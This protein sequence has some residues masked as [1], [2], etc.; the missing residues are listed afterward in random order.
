M[1]GAQ[2][3]CSPCWSDSCPRSG[4][5]AAPTSRSVR[6]ARAFALRSSRHL[7][8]TQAVQLDHTLYA[9]ADV[10]LATYQE[11]ADVT[12]AFHE[13]PYR[14]VD[15]FSAGMENPDDLFVS[16][17]E[18][19]GV[20]D[21]TVEGRIANPER[22]SRITDPQFRI[23]SEPRIARTPDRGLRPGSGLSTA[24]LPSFCRQRVFHRFEFLALQ[25]LVE[26]RQIDAENR[27]ELT[28]LFIQTIRQ[29]LEYRVR[30]IR[31]LVITGF[32]DALQCGQLVVQPDGIVERI[33]AAAISILVD[34]A[35]DRRQLRDGAA[36]PLP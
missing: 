27:V 33:L 20:V 12:L 36:P 21:V 2:T 30:L 14:P 15:L 8:G 1:T 7:P 34:L 25:Q 28:E 26:C 6:I 17:E 18:P 11:I 3:A 10:V 5:T 16:L 23:A 32:D 13:R 31:R 4:P 9:I 19:L 24:L 29:F 35:F 22:L